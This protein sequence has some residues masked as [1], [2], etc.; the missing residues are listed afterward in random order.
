MLPISRTQQYCA[1]MSPVSNAYPAVTT[2]LKKKHKQ[3]SEHV[4]T[5]PKNTRANCNQ[6]KV[7]G[8]A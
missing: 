3:M 7:Y 1:G 8:A 5:P 6:S 2:A 4:F